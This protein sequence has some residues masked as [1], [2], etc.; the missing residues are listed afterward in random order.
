MRWAD[1]IIRPE[2]KWGY[3]GLYYLGGILAT[4]ESDV[5]HTPYLAQKKK[6]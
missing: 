3:Q 5:T 4:F 6:F 2:N 1:R